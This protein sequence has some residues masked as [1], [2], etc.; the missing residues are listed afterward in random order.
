MVLSK[1][2]LKY[3]SHGASEPP[4]QMVQHRH[5]YWELVY[6]GGLG[7][8]TV[9][10]VAFNYLPGSYV[11][12]PR[13]VPHAEKALSHGYSREEARAILQK[14]CTEECL[15]ERNRKYECD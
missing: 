6:Y 5:E 15:D 11:V 3:F 14:N 1:T 8:S 13:N 10:G 4:Y 2:I 7:I 9:N 12:I